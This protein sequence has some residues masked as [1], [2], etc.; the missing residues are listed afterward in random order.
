MIIALLY[1]KINFMKE[2]FY[3][4]QYLFCL[5]NR[6]SKWKQYYSFCQK[7]NIVNLC[8]LQNFLKTKSLYDLDYGKFQGLLKQVDADYVWQSDQLNNIIYYSDKIYPYKLKQIADPP[9]VLYLKGN[10]ELLVHSQLLAIVGARKASPYGLDVAGDFSDK[11]SKNNIVIVS[12]LAFGIDIA[13]HLACIKNSLPSIAIMPAGLDHITP[14]SHEKISYKIQDKGLLISEVPPNVEPR[15]YHFP[16]RNRLISGIS[17]GVLVIEAK[18]NSGSLITARQAIE[19]NRPL[20]VIPGAIYNPLAQGCLHLIKQ[21]AACISSIEDILH[22][23]NFKLKVNQEDD[24]ECANVVLDAIGFSVTSI[25]KIVES[26]GF[27]MVNVIA[28]IVK[29]NQNGYIYPWCGGWIR[30]K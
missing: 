24:A 9:A 16:R 5:L 22:E 1:Y 20:M 18:I 27:T 25:E 26:T 11:L 4:E 2:I 12:G 17:D 23:L 30:V 3:E 7:N 29:L 8:D 13:C 10:V 28:E 19:Q 21:G 6:S 14:K 15:P